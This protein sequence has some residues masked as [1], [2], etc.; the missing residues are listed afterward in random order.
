[1]KK[2]FALVLNKSYVNQTDLYI[3]T[4]NR[5]AMVYSLIDSCGLLD[6]LDLIKPE[7][8]TKDQLLLFHC[9]EYI[10]F[11]KQCDKDYNNDADEN[12]QS[13][14][15]F[16]YDCPLKAGL[17]EYC[18]EIAGGSIEGARLLCHKKYRV[19]LHW[20][21]GWHHAKRSEAAG[22]CFVNDCVLAILKLRKT[23]SKVLYID[24]D[25]HHGDGVQDA[26]FATDKVMT[27][28]VHK[29]ESGFFPGTGSI[30]ET[31]FG[32]GKGF[33]I[34]LPLRDGI[35]DE[36][37]IS[38]CQKVL[39]EIKDV[40]LPDAVVCQ[41][42]ADGLNGDPMRSFNLTSISFEKCVNWVVSWDLPTLILGGGGYC[43]SNVA[44][45][46][47]QITASLLDETLPNDIPEHDYFVRYGPDFDFQIEPS[48]KKD[49]NSKEYLDDVIR[50]I[51]ST[52]RKLK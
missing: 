31:G 39:G 25:L 51:S 9:Q 33:S 48:L 49:L 23:F 29:Y 46:W 12:M 43:E 28:S 19:V 40:F 24:F 20:L 15:G 50:E 32:K 45:C 47:T 52:M 22:Y 11:L 2:Q 13:E 3:P 4:K 5:N 14:F 6:K 30:V 34:N 42:G 27:F 26:F 44:R 1:M 36:P 10:D 18:L 21:G 16:G 37:F 35:R 38:V 7:K 8:A 41:V 17:Y